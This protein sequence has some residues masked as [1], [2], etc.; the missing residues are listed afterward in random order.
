MD[1]MSVGLSVGLGSIVVVWC[2]FWNACGVLLNNMLF[3]CFIRFQFVFY[4]RKQN[5]NCPPY[6]HPKCVCMNAFIAVHRVFIVMPFQPTQP[7]ATS[8]NLEGLKIYPFNFGALAIHS[9]RFYSNFCCHCCCCVQ[10]IVCSWLWCYVC[11]W[12]MN[13]CEF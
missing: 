5:F 8:Q 6:P 11:I 10:R 2:S 3:V 13:T 4:N 12:R 9:A 7:S 1:H